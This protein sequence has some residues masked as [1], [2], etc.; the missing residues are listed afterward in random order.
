MIYLDTSALVKLIF[1][2]RESDALMRWLEERSDEAKLSSQ[3]AVI[4]LIRTCRRQDDAAVSGARQLLAGLDLV[5][6]SEDVVEGAALVS[7]VE[8]RSLDAIHL[9]SAM[10]VF[11]GLNSFVVYDGR[12]GT[13]AIE[14]GL[15]VVSPV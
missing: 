8:L 11:D 7:P 1:E 5:V 10:S 2:E 12:L 15:P 9:A 14:A 4:E 13:A 6:L 3:V